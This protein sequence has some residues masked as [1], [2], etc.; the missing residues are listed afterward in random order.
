MA[1]HSFTV[2]T[3]DEAAAVDRRL[4]RQFALARAINLP[5]ATDVAVYRRE[6]A[7]GVRFFFSNAASELFMTLVQFHGA[8]RCR[9]PRLGRDTRPFTEGSSP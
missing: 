3:R 7:G 6:G 4:E 1:W 5:L 2:R 9:R 8:R